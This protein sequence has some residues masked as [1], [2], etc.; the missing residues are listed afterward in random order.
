MTL[1]WNLLSSENACLAKKYA[2]KA[3]NFPASCV[4]PQRRCVEFGMLRVTPQASSGDAKRYYASADYYTEGQELIGLWGGKGAER[5][6]LKGVVDKMAFDRLCD[7]LNPLDGKQLTPRTRG[8]RTVLYDFT[9]SVPKSVSLLYSMTGDEQILDAFRSAVHDTMLDI[10]SEMKTRVR[11][12]GKDEN[13][14]TG[15]MVWAEFIHKTSRPV[16]GVPDPQLH[17]HYGDFQ[18]HV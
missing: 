3:G 2:K 10:E 18:R 16:N 4:S 15:N 17:I 9:W 5:L 1:A 11:R 13:R 8:D 12:N 14:T 7:N 6:G